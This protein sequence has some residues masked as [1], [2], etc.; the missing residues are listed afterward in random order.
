MA[1]AKVSQNGHIV[2]PAQ[3]RRQ[4]VM[5]AGCEVVMEPRDEGILILPVSGESKQKTSPFD[6]APA[7]GLWKDDL[8]T[9]EEMSDELGGNW[10]GI[11]LEA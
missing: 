8:R 3:L 10:T 2:I 9:D 1:T 4:M 7:F 5:E 6:A 11:P